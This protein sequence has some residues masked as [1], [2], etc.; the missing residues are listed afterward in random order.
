MS[1]PT[2]AE[3]SGNKILEYYNLKNLQY[4]NQLLN[5]IF[6]NTYKSAIQ[7]RKANFWRIVEIPSLIFTI[8]N[9]FIF[10][11]NWIAG[12]VTI[13]L[14]TILMCF[15]ILL[16]YNRKVKKLNEDDENIMKL[17][18]IIIAIQ[19]LVEEI[20]IIK[21]YSI[22]IQQMI[23]TDPIKEKIEQIKFYIANN[24]CKIWESVDFPNLSLSQ[25]NDFLNRFNVD[26]DR[27]LS[28]L[29]RFKI[30]IENHIDNYEQ[31]DYYISLVDM[32]SKLEKKIKTKERNNE[33]ISTTAST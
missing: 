1:N 22:P 32:I 9:L 3:G 11:I 19:Y 8:S 13:I 27:F 5:Y 16:I 14:T 15:V 28:I 30:F 29:N 17:T 4:Q 23:K 33:R 21:K 18:N 6:R 7:Q 2:K 20:E 31:G 10:Y 24:L 25:I 26:I 12:L